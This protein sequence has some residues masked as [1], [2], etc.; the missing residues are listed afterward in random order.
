MDIRRFFFRNRGV[1]PIP[2]ALVILYFSQPDLSIL[3]IGFLILIAGETLRITGV[4]Y[5]GGITRT[6]TVGAPSLCTSGPFSY[7]RNPLYLHLDIFYYSV[8]AD[9]FT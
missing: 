8:W 2:L 9:Y 4:R 1:T 6:T 3:W 7:V 5:A